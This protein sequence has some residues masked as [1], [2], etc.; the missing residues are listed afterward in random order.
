MICYTQILGGEEDD[1]QE[2]D[3]TREE[4]RSVTRLFK[5]EEENGVLQT[6]TTGEE[7]SCFKL[8]LYIGRRE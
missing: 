1:L 4:E 6:D 7:E 5:G 8:F 3:A 2:T